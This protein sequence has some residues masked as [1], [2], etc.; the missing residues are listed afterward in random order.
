VSERLTTAALEA[1][2]GRPVRLWA[3]NPE[4][5]AA[6]R[7]AG[8]AEARTLLRLEC[9][10]PF[11]GRPNPPE[12]VRITRFRQGVDEGAFLLVSNEAFADH[13]D[14]SG[15]DRAVLEERMSREWF[16]PDGMFLA[17]ERGRP[18]G[19]C[20]TKL[21]PGRVGEIYSIA[22]RPGAGGRGL[23]TVLA[24]RGLHHLQAVAGARRGLL[25]ADRANERAVAVYRTL[26]FEPVRSTSEFVAG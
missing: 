20:W 13:P 3:K 4:A 6:A 7:A 14:S 8:L 24:T 17:W 15:W 16:D 12:G 1:A 9:P 5:A 11:P 10:L 21:H 18:V 26:G 25:Y 23:G 22:V 19:E 2:A